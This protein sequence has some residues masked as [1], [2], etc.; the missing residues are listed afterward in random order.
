M[1]LVVDTEHRPLSPCHP[2]RARQL[3]SHGKVAGWRRYPFT[4][5]CKRAA[6]EPTIAGRQVGRELVRASGS[7]DVATVT[8]RV[9]GISYRYCHVVARGDGYAYSDRWSGASSPA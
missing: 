9:Q 8:G 4:I 6:S 5:L 3:L 2:A 1:V 7:F